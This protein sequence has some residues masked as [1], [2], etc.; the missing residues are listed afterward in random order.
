ML[1][2]I[3]TEYNVGQDVDTVHNGQH[4]VGRILRIEITVANSGIG[5]SVTIDYVTEGSQHIV[6][7]HIMPLNEY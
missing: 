1:L 6:K 5:N 7:H 4:I 3:E 2:N